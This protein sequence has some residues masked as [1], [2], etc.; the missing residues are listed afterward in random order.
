MLGLT[1]S[2]LIILNIVNNTGAFLRLG[3]S[4]SEVTVFIDDLQEQEP[5]CSLCLPPHPPSP[6]PFPSPSFSLPYPL[7]L[8]VALSPFSPQ[9]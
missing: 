4:N 1:S 7:S 3:F 9:W 5:K 8:S 2:R 6:S